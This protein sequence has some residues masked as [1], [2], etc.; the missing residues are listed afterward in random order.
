[1]E[2]TP[3]DNFMTTLR[4]ALSQAQANATTSKAVHAADRTGRLRL[5]LDGGAISVELDPDLVEDVEERARTRDAV[6]EAVSALLEEQRSAGQVDP[7]VQASLAR[8]AEAF[9]ASGQDA[10]QARLQEAEE[11]FGRFR[12]A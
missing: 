5:T 9:F 10:L 11:R 7:A 3:A 8:E 12:R 2:T 4:Q 1:M 6:R